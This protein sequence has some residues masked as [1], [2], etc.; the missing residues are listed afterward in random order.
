MAR[1]SNGSATPASSPSLVKIDT[2]L[3]YMGFVR[4]CYTN[5]PACPRTVGQAYGM[6][7]VG[8]IEQVGFSSPIS[9]YGM[10]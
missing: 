4:N 6:Q 2:A 3:F 8:L 9:A 10:S 7:A 5:N 1:D